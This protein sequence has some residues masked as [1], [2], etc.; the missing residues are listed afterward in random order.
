M[1]STGQGAIPGSKKFWN[2]PEDLSKAVDRNNWELPQP[3]ENAARSYCVQ[4]YRE[5]WSP[6][7]GATGLSYH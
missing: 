2:G 3:A 7:A 1:L 5:E 6:G 4:Q